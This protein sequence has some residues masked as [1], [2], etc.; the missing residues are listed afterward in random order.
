MARRHRSPDAESRCR[1]NGKSCIKSLHDV[2]PGGAD[3]R[4]A[5]GPNSRPIIAFSRQAA[6]TAMIKEHLLLAR[7]VIPA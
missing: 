5:A 6:E 7:G 3:L 1:G 2:S 4:L